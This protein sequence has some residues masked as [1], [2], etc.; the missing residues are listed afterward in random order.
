MSDKCTA[1]KRL[2][3]DNADNTSCSAC[4]SSGYLCTRDPGHSGEHV[5]CG[6]G[7]DEHNLDIW[8]DTT[9]EETER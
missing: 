1:D 9:Q 2:C 3:F 6:L 5:A 7:D 4:S 8:L